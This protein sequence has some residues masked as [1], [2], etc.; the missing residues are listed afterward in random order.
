MKLLCNTLLFPPSSQ[1]PQICTVRIFTKFGSYGIAN[2]PRPKTAAV[3]RAQ[4]SDPGSGGSAGWLCALAPFLPGLRHAHDP[5]TRPLVITTAPGS[6]AGRPARFPR[7]RPCSGHAPLYPLPLV[8]LQVNPKLLELSPDFSRERNP[9]VVLF[10][11]NQS[12][13]KNLVK[14]IFLKTWH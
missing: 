2:M 7:H 5:P 9:R 13:I 6:P 14:I 8:L 3:E 4:V 1:N 11:F 12:G 10:C